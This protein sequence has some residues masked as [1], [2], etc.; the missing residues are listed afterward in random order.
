MVFRISCI[1]LIVIFGL[2]PAAVLAR[3]NDLDGHLVVTWQPPAY[4][5][6]LHHYIWSYTINGVTDSLRGTS[7]AADT[8]NNSVTLS[9]VG[10]WAIF[11]IRAVSTVND[12]SSAAVSDTA[13]YNT[14]LGIGPPRGVTW[15]Q[16][17]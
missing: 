3:F 6:P 15:I 4:G 14:G 1:M 5:N 9:N 7:P 2:I 11:H 16:G 12:T 8:L 10:D 13:F 17:P